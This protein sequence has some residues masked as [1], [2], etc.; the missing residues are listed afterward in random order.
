M[1]RKL[2]PTI[3]GALK[4]S[5][6]N[7]GSSETSGDG[8]TPAA[9]A[10]ALTK[11]VT[12]NPHSQTIVVLKD[13][14]DSDKMKESSAELDNEDDD[15]DSDDG[16]PKDGDGT[17]AT[18]TEDLVASKDADGKQALQIQCSRCMVTKSPKS[19]NKQERMRGQKGNKAR[20][21]SCNAF[22]TMLKRKFDIK[23][24]DYDF[25][26]ADQNG[27][28][29]LCVTAPIVDKHK[30]D[31]CQETKTFRGVLCESCFLVIAGLGKPTIDRAVDLVCYLAKN[32]KPEA[33]EI[34]TCMITRVC[35]AFGVKLD[36]K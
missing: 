21:M 10:V 32:N 4:T 19:F 16:S 6:G 7:G 25:K 5:K 8:S 3:T 9:P 15:G 18:S 17:D 2:S 24:I 11:T 29:A 28:C 31:W 20:C 33:D 23:L 36:H 12:I 14:S 22:R 1:S 26:V 30:I 27:K 34:E 13:K 35:E